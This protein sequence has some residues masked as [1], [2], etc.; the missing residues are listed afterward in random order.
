[1]N[2]DEV[3]FHLLRAYG[4]FEREVA[5]ARVRLILG[6]T[7]WLWRVGL[8][9][10]GPVGGI[11]GRNCRRRCGAADGHR[12]TNGL[13]IGRGVRAMSVAPSTAAR[14]SDESE[15]AGPSLYISD[16]HHSFL[17]TSRAMERLA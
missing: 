8:L 14:Q 5:A 6:T 7:A 15:Q 17:C 10:I 4:Q 9:R 13:T 3:R 2:Q 16:R 11:T 1:L 12:T